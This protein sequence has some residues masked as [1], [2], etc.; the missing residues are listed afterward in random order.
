MF[1]VCL[2]AAALVMSTPRF[3]GGDAVK[4]KAASEAHSEVGHESRQNPLSNC[5]FGIFRSPQMFVNEAIEKGHPISLENFLPK[6]LEEAINKAVSVSSKELNASVHSWCR[7]F[8]S[9]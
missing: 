7:P 2:H 9:I 3:A 4:E 5:S 1:A 6:P 8:I